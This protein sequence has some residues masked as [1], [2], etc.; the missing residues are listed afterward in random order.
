MPVFRV[1]FLSLIVFSNVVAATAE[2]SACGTTVKAALHGVVRDASGKI[3]RRMPL[4]SNPVIV[5]T[6]MVIALVEQK[7]RPDKISQ[8]LK[9]Y[10]DRFNRMFK[11]KHKKIADSHLYMAERSV[12]ERFNP[13]NNGTVTFPTSIRIFEIEGSRNSPE[14]QKLLKKFEDLQVGQVKANSANDREIVA[15]LFFARR[16]HT[17]DIPTFVTADSGIYGPLC[18]FVPACAGLRG[19]P[20]LVKEAFSSGYIVEIDI[21]GVARKVRIIPF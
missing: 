11:R 16:S 13:N 19:N 8:N 2:K 10:A 21:G 17:E 3:I 1:L 7:Y 12:T 20:K 9:K 6:N 18:R 15:D 4:G 14:Y 5:D